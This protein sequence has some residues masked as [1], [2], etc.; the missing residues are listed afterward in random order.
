MQ[1]DTSLTAARIG[2]GKVVHHYYPGATRTSCAAGGMGDAPAT[3]VDEAITCK[4]CLKSLARDVEWAH[5]T[6]IA[7]DAARTSAQQACVE[8]PEAGQALKLEP[9]TRLN[10][11]GAVI[12]LVARIAEIGTGLPGWTVKV[13][14]SHDSPDMDGYVTEHALVEEGATPALPPARPVHVYNRSN[15]LLYVVEGIEGTLEG[16]LVWLRAVNGGATLSVS[17]RAL[18]DR[19]RACCRHEEAQGACVHPECQSEPFKVGDRIRNRRSGEIA[20]VFRTD[21]YWVRALAENDST[22]LSGVHADWTPRPIEV[23]LRVGDLVAKRSTGKAGRVVFVGGNWAEPV[24]HVESLGF[25]E[26]G[27]AR[28]YEPRYKAVPTITGRWGV[29]VTSEVSQ[30]ALRWVLDGQRNALRYGTFHQANA[31]AVA[32]YRG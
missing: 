7:E 22:E 29:I 32:M 25:E 11:R 12:Q 17:S 16:G 24:V 10:H 31:Q 2:K 18:C 9:G 14:I 23:T 20:Y 28:D 5:E 26:I 21:G 1:H 15:G 13:H 4:T 8:A 30:G 27:K 6:A 3:I 19:F